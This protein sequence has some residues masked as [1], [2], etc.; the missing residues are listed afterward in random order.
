MAG[1]RQQHAAAGAPS[2]HASGG[3]LHCRMRC[4]CNRAP[5]AVK[6]LHQSL[7]LVTTRLIQADGRL[8]GV[9]AECQVS[10]VQRQLLSRGQPLQARQCG[11]Q[12]DL[13]AHVLA[14]C[15]QHESKVGHGMGLSASF[16]VR[17]PALRKGRQVSCGSTAG[18]VSRP[19]TPPPHHRR[20]LASLAHVVVQP[21]HEAGVVGHR[22]L[23]GLVGLWHVHKHAD[24]D[25]RVVRE[26]QKGG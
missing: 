5:L 1:E 24:V 6:T 10:G 13:V 17:A 21:G 3:Q 15:S 22:A 2:T 19:T 20:R 12:I 26:V 18:G 23:G 11:R 16:R 9:G 7:S 14:A 25:L 4:D 8:S